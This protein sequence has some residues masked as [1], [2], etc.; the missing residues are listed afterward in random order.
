M[1]ADAVLHSR[2]IA[3]S[4]LG[5][6]AKKA[7]VPIYATPGGCRV[8]QVRVIP[9]TLAGSNQTYSTWISHLSTAAIGDA[10]TVF[11]DVARAVVA[12]SSHAVA[13]QVFK[14]AGEDDFYVFI[15]SVTDHTN[16]A[17]YVM[18]ELDTL[19]AAGFVVE[20]VFLDYGTYTQTKRSLL[21]VA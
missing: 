11:A 10:D 14:A 21:E 9:T 12:G 13:E 6:T 15:Q 19:A 16:H 4:L 3:V 17:F 18:V 2:R 5:G 1:H 20:V 8:L 7:A